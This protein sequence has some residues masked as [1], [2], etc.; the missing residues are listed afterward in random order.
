MPVLTPARALGAVRPRLHPRDLPAPGSQRPRLRAAADTRGDGH[1]AREG[2]PSYRQLPQ[3]LYH[4]SIKERDEPRPR[5]GLLRLRE[6][7][8]KDAYSFDRDEAGLDVSFRKHEEAYH[9]IFQRCGL[10]YSA[11]QA[12]SGMM[13][14]KESIDFLAPSGSGEN[15]LVTCENGDYAADLEIARACRASRSSR[16]GST[17]RRRSTTPGV[18]TIEALAE[19]LGIDSAATSKAMPVAEARRTLVLA[20]IRGDDRLEEAKMR[21]R[22]R[23]TSRPATDEEIQAALRRRPGLARPGR[24]RGRGRGRRDA[25]R[26]PVRRGREPRRLP[27]ARRRGRA[28]LRGRAS[29]TSAQPLEGDS[30]PGLRRRPALPDRDRGGAHLQV[31]HA[32]LGAAR[33]DVPRRGRRREAADRR[34]LRNRARRG[35]WPPSSSSSTTRTASSGRRRSRPT[36]SHVV[37]LPG[38]EERALEAA[39]A[40]SDAGRRARRRPRAAG[41]REVRRRRPDR[42]PRPR[43]RSARRRSTTAPWTS[44]TARRARSGVWR[45]P[46]SGRRGLDGA[47]AAVQPRA[48]RADARA[49]DGR[50]GRDVPRAR[51]RGRTSRP[52]T[53]TTSSTA[54]AR[55]RRTT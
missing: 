54:T 40:L 53:S 23:A 13:G 48:L 47:P 36:T 1:L 7:I 5:G 26:G 46:T 51:R 43:S 37:A 41:G 49:A 52:A 12:E 20:L 25:A 9:R 21:R 31:R 45:S 16:R 22:S 39:Q 34:L 8:M 30:L 29:P 10:E 32:L 33:R 24:L 28:R 44:V 55:C 27:S 38:L 42:H 6:F 17:R 15:M 35:S 11:V 3:M 19:L 50:D 4:F 2:D 14:G 18:T